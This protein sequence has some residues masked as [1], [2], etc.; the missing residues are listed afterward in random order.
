MKPFF[1]LLSSRVI[2]LFAN[3]TKLLC[4]GFHFL[5]PKKRFVLPAEAAPLISNKKPS[6]IPR[7]I[8]QTNYTNRVTLPVYLNY[9]F[10]R[11]MAPGFAYRF[12]VTEARA[13]FIKANFSDEIFANYSRIQIGAAQADFWRLLVLQKY[14]GVYLDIDAHVV[15][16]L[17]YIVRPEFDELYIRTK[18]GEI[19]NYFIASKPENPHLAQMI[20]LVLRNIR[21]CRLTNVY[22]L[23]G[24]GVFNKVLDINTVNT[25]Y[26]RYTCNQ[27]SFTNEYFQYVDKP[28]GKW[29][30]EQEKIDIIRKD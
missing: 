22:E 14:G 8:W 10:N 27:G 4:Y 7:I 9:L 24:P 12:M 11:L 1:I 5:F 17:G 30:R 21:E 16:P 13:E 18:R 28:Q 2:R 15:W 19:S 3:I 26:Y 6:T 23:T 29:T 25:T 20:D